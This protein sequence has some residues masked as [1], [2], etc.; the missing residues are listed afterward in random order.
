MSFTDYDFPHTNM[1]DS[2]LREILANMRKLEKIVENF[3]HLETITFAD[4][5]QWNINKQYTA[6]TIVLDEYGNAYLSK[7]PV[8]KGILLTDEDYWQIIFNYMEY[9]KAFDSNLTLNSERL[10]ERAS[11]AYTVGE[12]LLWDDILYEVIAN[13]AFDELFDVDTNLTR[14]TV[15]QFCRTWKNYLVNLVNQYK[16]DIDASE[17]QYKADIDASEAAYRQQL[18]QDIAT[19]TA[20]LQAQLDAAIS[21][22]TVDSEV[23]NARIG[24]NGVTYPTLGSAIRSQIN[25]DDTLVKMHYDQAIPGQLAWEL[26]GINTTG[27]YAGKNNTN[28]SYVRT[29]GHY[30]FDSGD[31]VYCPLGFYLQAFQ[32]TYDTSTHQYTF[33]GAD[34][35]I[36][37]DFY[38]LSDTY[39][40]RFTYRKADSSA[41]SD[42]NDANK[43]FTLLT[44]SNYQDFNKYRLSCGA[45]GD[46]TIGNTPA[47][48]DG[49]VTTQWYLPL[50]CV[51]PKNSFIESITFNSAVSQD[52]VLQ[53]G[54]FRRQADSA[55]DNFYMILLDKIEWAGY[56]AQGDNDIYLG[57]ETH[58]QTYIGF[59]TMYANS[60]NYSRSA[61]KYGY[62]QFAD[63]AWVSDP[64]SLSYATGSA[65]YCVIS[66]ATR[67]KMNLFKINYHFKETPFV[68]K[69]LA[70]IGDSISTET[71]RRTY[72]PYYELLGSE[73]GFTYVPWAKGGRAYDPQ[74]AGGVG[75]A[76]YVAYVA[77]QYYEPDAIII[78]AGVNDYG[79]SSRP[80]GDITSP[81]N[82]N[83]IYGCM[84]RCYDAIMTEFQYTPTLIMSP[85]PMAVDDGDGNYVNAYNQPNAVGWTLGDVVEAEGE[86]T[87][88]YG[89]YFINMYERSPLRPWEDGTDNKFYNGDYTH[90]TL[91]GHCVM[92]AEIRN[93]V[94]KIFPELYSHDND[95]FSSPYAD[96]V[97]HNEY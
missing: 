13:I 2:D 55:N 72:Y 80:L 3:V 73:Y 67:Q 4:P 9:I 60:V 59:R 70:V 31:R 88:A 23:I 42:L 83:S 63:S 65:F 91:K 49:T 74:V 46:Y 48:A 81:A 75:M 44:R 64:Y 52:I 34:T 89:L 68:G 76:N 25:F 84:K 97:A 85:I 5:I 18:A 87:E 28:T 45:V 77:Q 36:T 37:N 53:I 20:S 47:T 86:L 14:M 56:V 92:A 66:D 69:K 78:F 41:I 17:A 94:R 1:Y 6:S 22:A 58:C 62:Y 43:F 27:T 40:Y 38:E 7:Q 50:D 26:N 96:M 90:P 35:E 57:I 33:V 93:A 79:G 24:A 16:T 61:N 54:I 11:R 29:I 32:Y 82:Y 19:T 95:Y 30:T 8:E 39:Y 12:W 15:E 51:V 71:M 21:G 10:T